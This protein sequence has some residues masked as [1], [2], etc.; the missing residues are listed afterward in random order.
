M[1]VDDRFESI[2]VEAKS[3]NGGI[4]LRPSV[5]KPVSSLERLWAYLTVKQK[6]EE[7]EISD[8]KELK[9][10]ALYLAIKYSFVTDL[11][12]LVVVKP[13]DT[14]RA[15]IEDARPGSRIPEPGKH[16]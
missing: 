1:F 5:Q 13:N 14:E 6:L 10:E 2:S 9:S 11:T 12:S 15:E 3:S 7:S 8:N 16:K 4:S